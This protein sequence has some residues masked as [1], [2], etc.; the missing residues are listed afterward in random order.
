MKQLKLNKGIVITEDEE[1]E[2]KVGKKS[3]RIVPLWEF[4]LE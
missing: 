4:L 3:I 2:I 1:D